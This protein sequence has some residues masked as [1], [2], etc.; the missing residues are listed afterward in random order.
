[1]ELSHDGPNDMAFPGLDFPCRRC[2]V[3]HLRRP[4]RAPIKALTIN[5][6]P[7]AITGESVRLPASAGRLL[8]EA[9]Y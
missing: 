5:G 1:M 9:R 8:I 4:D 2:F 6:R 7:A 3:L